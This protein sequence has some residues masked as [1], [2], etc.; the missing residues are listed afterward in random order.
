MLLL[1]SA[2]LRT[3][4]AGHEG[5]SQCR[6]VKLGIC[7]ESEEPQPWNVVVQNM[8]GNLLECAVGQIVAWLKEVYRFGCTSHAATFVAPPE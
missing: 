3:P 6:A 7:S 5:V 2:E 8:P 4:L 1:V